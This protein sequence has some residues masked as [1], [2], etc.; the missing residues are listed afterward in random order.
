LAQ[1]RKVVLKLIFKLLI[2]GLLFLWF[3]S[4]VDIFELFSS[5]SMLSIPFFL[6]VFFLGLIANFINT[7]KWKIF[8]PDYGLF[9]LFIYNYLSI[10]YSLFLP[11]SQF[12]GETMK[13]YKLG[14]IKRNYET[15]AA[16]V[17]MDRTTGLISLLFI[18]IFCIIISNNSFSGVLLP[19]YIFSTLLFIILL[20]IFAI[21]KL[22]GFIQ[23]SYSRVS[24]FSIVNK[25]ILSRIKVFFGI[26]HKFI[27]KPGLITQAVL[28]GVIFQILSVYIIYSLGGMLS[29]HV[30]FSD[31]CWIMGLVFLLMFIPISISG[32]GV[33]EGSLVVLLGMFGI[34]NE[35]AL[36][37]SLI[38]FALQII[39]GLIGGIL[40]Y[41]R[42]IIFKNKFP[43]AYS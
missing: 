42:G 29:I 36:S 23:A 14:R 1:K 33:R 15:I 19:W 11:G 43:A 30:P 16:S 38:M 10:F 8:L 12:A 35:K 24:T 32:I 2:S 13:V 28:I 40:W 22:Y 7:I 31:W 26:W 25:K 34:A 37:L 18:G 41:Y 17:I 27:R 6:Y 9:G 20:G 3:F 21:P 39:D 5:L 4:R